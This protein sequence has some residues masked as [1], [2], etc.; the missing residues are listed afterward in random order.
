MQSL[1]DA[2]KQ[3][4]KKM[5]TPQKLKTEAWSPVK[6][7][8]EDIG[9]KSD[10]GVLSQFTSLPVCN[11]TNGTPGVDCDDPSPVVNPPSASLVASPEKK[12]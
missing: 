7:D 2:E 8:V 1:A 5:G 12:P 4:G 9:T 10:H 3:M 6:Y 11:G